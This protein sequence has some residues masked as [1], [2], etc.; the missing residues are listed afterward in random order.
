MSKLLS[1]QEAAQALGLSEDE[2]NRLRESG[3]IYAYRDAGTW[4]FKPEE[5]ERYKA[6][7]SGGEK[8]GDDL[9]LSADDDLPVELGEE[10][11]D[12]LVLLSDLELGGSG[13]GTASTIIGRTDSGEP[14]ADSD[15]ELADD[16]VSA[17]P[18]SDVTLVPG[19]DGSDVKLVSGSDVKLADD[20]DDEAKLVETPTQ[21]VSGDQLELEPSGS[22][23]RISGG[24]EAPAADKQEEAVALGSDD[25]DLSLGSDIKLEDSA[26]T[27]GDEP[28]DDEAKTQ[29][30]S[31]QR[32]LGDSDLTLSPSDSGIS[33]GSPA[34][35][36]ISLE[37][38]SGSDAL[39]L[40]D[41]SSEL[42]VEGDFLLTPMEDVEE[43]VSQDSGSQVIVLDEDS[44][45]DL[46][47]AT[48]LGEESA[49]ME[50]MLE[51]D[52]LGEDL[53]TQA[54]A[55]PMVAQGPA[56][57]EAPF[58]IG[59]V[60]GLALCVMI[61]ALGGMM[62]FDLVRHMWSWD[63]PLTLNSSLMDWIISMFGG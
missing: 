26:L 25:I 28:V 4:K 15:I 56:V 31:G 16:E 40:S 35:S 38:A 32:A 13:P 24:E 3:E 62:M 33:L 43:D 63:R 12:E 27:L 46:A 41:A 10:D 55:E 47:S 7:Q 36:G 61:L 58:T 1:I 50:P 6:A 45:S 48:L 2:V 34:D 37:G 51:E 14:S 52:A 57:R 39:G 60:I 18:A 49:G 42:A 59:N 20:A 8:E 11:S 23:I 19:G 29:L 22:T 21:I 17:K 44:E 54:I 5:I 30:V 9:I 53:E